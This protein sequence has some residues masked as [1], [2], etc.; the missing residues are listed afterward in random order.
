MILAES[1]ILR[2]KD[3]N[4]EKKSSNEWD[5][6]PT[7]KLADVEKHIVRKV[8]DKHNN[9]LTKAANEL[10]ISRTTLY[11]KIEKYGL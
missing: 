1:D 9:N 3:F 8:L 10:N 5:T 6:G 11:L 4:M 2:S 7:N